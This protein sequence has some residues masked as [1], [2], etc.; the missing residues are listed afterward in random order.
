M[1]FAAEKFFPIVN[2]VIDPEFS[3]LL[4]ERR[5][6]RF[7]FRVIETA[8][9]LRKT[10][11]PT[12]W[13]HMG[14]AFSFNVYAHTL[15]K[16]S[17]ATNLYTQRCLDPLQQNGFSLGKNDLVFIK[18]HDNAFHHPLLKTILDKMGA[19]TLLISG[20]NTSA[21][22]TKTLRGALANGFKCIVLT[23]RLADCEYPEGK[24][25]GCSS[26]HEQIIRSRLRPGEFRPD[27][28]KYMLAE[29]V[30]ALCR[31]EM[32]PWLRQQKNQSISPNKRPT[33]AIRRSFLPGRLS[34]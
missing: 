8:H 1:N 10:G 11:V 7:R 18:G 27:A 29:D 25:G 31:K 15:V 19:R 17:S 12:I 5:A 21:C 26:W 3:V 2:V 30:L 28:I 20:M 24:R 9:S 6:R 16:P 14:E 23:N 32:A 13:I 33:T 34:L 22:V 4:P